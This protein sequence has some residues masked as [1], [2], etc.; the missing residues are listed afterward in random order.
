MCVQILFLQKKA[1]DRK[2]AFRTLNLPEDA[3]QPTILKRFQEHAA[4]LRQRIGNAPAHLRPQ[5]QEALLQLEEAYRMLAI[6]AASTDWLPASDRVSINTPP[7]AGTE[8]S[9]N[10]T[11][12]VPVFQFSGG[13]TTPPLGLMQRAGQWFFMGMVVALAGMS[14]FGFKSCEAN[15]ELEKAR[16]LAEKTEKYQQI[17]KNGKFKVKNSGD[18]PF[19]I[20][21]YKVFYIQSDSIVEYRPNATFSKSPFLME[22]GK[23]V[24]EPTLMMGS[25]HI[26]DGEVLFYMIV[27][28]NEDSESQVF[29]GIWQQDEALALNPTFK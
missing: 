18:K 2:S 28:V 5:F 8:T 7:I 27:V 19:W 23:T 29:S 20:F 6:N 3:D 10:P 9:L 11:S 26:Y 12:Q 25:K 22:P 24:F 15:K 16:P 13:Q 1:M 17:V 21:N 4:D 14:F